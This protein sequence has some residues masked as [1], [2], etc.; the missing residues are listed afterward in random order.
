MAH[1]LHIPPHSN[2]GEGARVKTNGGD[3]GIYRRAS[4]QQPREDLLQLEHNTA[5]SILPEAPFKG[6]V[7]VGAQ[8]MASRV[9]ICKN[10]FPFIIS[11]TSLSSSLSSFRLPASETTVPLTYL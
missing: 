6:N 7:T 5:S 11:V 9:E 3:F 2:K 10:A 1:P 4:S 8:C